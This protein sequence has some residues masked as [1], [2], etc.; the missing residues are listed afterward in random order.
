MT[1]IRTLCLLAVSAGAVL[2]GGVS[3]G[4]GA[5]AKGI[6]CALLCAIAYAGMILFSKKNR[7]ITGSGI[8]RYS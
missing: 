1:L 8:R 2:T 7:S 5:D 6:A 4:H 3:L